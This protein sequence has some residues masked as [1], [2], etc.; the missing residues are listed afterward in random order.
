MGRGIIKL[1]TVPLA[2]ELGNV[3]IITKG[4][5]DDCNSKYVLLSISAVTDENGPA[6]RHFKDIIAAGRRLVC[7]VEKNCPDCGGSSQYALHTACRGCAKAHP[8]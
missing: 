4:S 7:E 2:K 3:L 1:Y 8:D 6:G 5:I